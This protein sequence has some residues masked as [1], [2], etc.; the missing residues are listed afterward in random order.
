M[1]N[2]APVDSTEDIVGQNTTNRLVVHGATAG[3]ARPSNAT[4]VL[5][6][7]SVTPT[8]ASDG[9]IWLDTT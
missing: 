9:D 8:N 3:T 6:I 7:G 1:K 5:W 4:V 2:L